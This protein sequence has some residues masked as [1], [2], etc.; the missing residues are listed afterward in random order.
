ML[1][2]IV[3]KYHPISKGQSFINYLFLEVIF[4][5]TVLKKEDHFKLSLVIDKYRGIIINIHD[6]YLLDHI[7]PIFDKCKTLNPIQRKLLRRAVHN[8]NKIEE[9]C[10]G[11]V[12][13]VT[14]REISIIDVVL[15]IELQKLFGQLYKY[16]IDREPFYSVYGHK[17]D[18]YKGIIGNETTCSC[19]GVGT[20][21]NNH[22]GPVGA[23]DHYFPIN[24]YPFSSINFRNLVPICDICNS[25]YKTQKDTLYEIKNKT[26]KRKRIQNIIKH[27]AFFP[28]SKEYE[29]IDISVSITNNELSNLTKDDISIVYFL[30]DHREEIINWERLFNVSEI[31]TSNLLDNATRAFINVQFD[32]MKLGITFDECCNLYADNLFYDKNFIR[33]PYLKEYY[34]ILTV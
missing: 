16:V 31:H 10:K 32:M 23:L 18:F 13:P 19:C 7:V 6:E 17:S 11:N 8:N 26:K 3:Y 9:L 15:S 30:P 4:N 28:Y 22:Q 5:N 21:L 25:K 12:E 34:R 29:M 33:L 1:K 14:Y 2:P 27:K 20:M 24:H